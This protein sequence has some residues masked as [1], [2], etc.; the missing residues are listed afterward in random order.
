M[1]QIKQPVFTLAIT[2]LSAIYHKMTSKNKCFQYLQSAF[3]YS[4]KLLDNESQITN[5]KNNADNKLN[6]IL[7]IQCIMMIRHSENVEMPTHNI[8]QIE[9][10][11]LKL[12][13]DSH[14]ASSNSMEIPYINKYL[15]QKKLT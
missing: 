7:A 14:K 10:L 15:E 5:N 8:K 2:N 4:K 11:M 3:E 12:V 9:K 1:N 13:K 6:S